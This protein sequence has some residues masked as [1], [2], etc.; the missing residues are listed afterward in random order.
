[1]RR[2]AMMFLA[3]TFLAA[4]ASTA[5]ATV[6]YPPGPP[7]RSCPDSVTLY[8]VQRDSTDGNTCQPAWGDTV[9]G[10]RGIVG[11]FRLRST[12]RIY[13]VNS[14]A[15]DYNGLQIYT[16]GHMESQGIAIG[17][18][19]SVCGISSVYQNE[20]EIIGTLGTSL[21]VRKIS[22]GNPLP[23]FRVGT[24]TTYKWTPASGAGS[25]YATCNPVEGMLVRVNGPLKVARRGPG[26]GLSG[27]GWWLCVNADGSA[28]GD[29]LLVEGAV[30]TAADIIAPPLGTTI[31]WVQGIMRRSSP[32]GTDAW[33]ISLRNASDISVQAP[34]NLSMAYPIAENKV[35]VV[36][37]KN[38]DVTTAQNTGNYALGSQLSGS[39][40]DNATVVG[41]AG[42][43]VDL[44]ISDI[45]P[46]FSVESV[47]T[48]GIG[49]ATCP[50][51]L[52]TQQSM[53]FILGVLTC[54]EVQAPLPDSLGGAHCADVS[55][56][57]GAGSALG[58]RVTVRGVFVA[59]YPV[60]R[61]FYFEDPEGGP[62]SGVVAYNVPFGP[63]VGHQY[64]LTCRVQEYYTM[65]EL[66]EPVAMIDEGV[67][68]VPNPELQPV[69]VLS[70]MSC[71]A[72][73]TMSTAEDYEGVLVRVENAKVVTTGSSFRV[74]A[75]APDYPD[76][77]SVSDYDGLYTFAATDT[78]MVVN[79]TGELFIN[80][81]GPRIGPRSDAD[82]TVLSGSPPSTPV[83][84][85]PTDGAT[86]VP[87]TTSLTVTASDPD[88]D[89]LTVQ[90]YGRKV[91]TPPTGPEFT[92]VLLPDTQFYTSEE[93]GGS[94]AIFKAQ[95]QWIVNNRVSRNI[96]A[97]AQL[98]DVTDNNVTAEW[99]RAD[100]AMK[101]IEDPVTTGLPSGIPYVMD[102]G[103]HDGDGTLFNQ[104][105]GV[106][107]FNGRSYY[108]GH[109][110]S[111]N[112]NSYILFSGA[113]HDFVMV[114]LRYAPSSAVLAWAHG[115]LAAYPSRLGIVVSHSILNVGNPATWTT[116][117]QPIY[118]ALKDVPNL[119]LMVCG[120]MHG[121]GRR[122]DVYG[123]HTLTSL[124]SDYQG[125][126]NGGNGY[127][128]YYEFAPAANQVRART[129]SPWLSQYEVD[130]DSSSQ[131]TLN[132]L[133]FGG[134]SV[135]DFALLGTV[136]GVP[137]GS[138]AVFQWS[139]LD[140][141][142]PYQWYVNVSDSHTGR[143]GPTW[144]FTTGSNTGVDGGVPGALALGPPSPNPARGALRFSFDLP[145][146][147]R[148]RLDVV[149]VQGRVVDVLAEGD[150]V[151][152]RYERVWNSSNARNRAAGLYFVRLE[153]PEGRLVRRAALLH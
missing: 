24:T 58:E 3:L 99:M 151:A 59:Q 31:D 127:L 145:R 144:S 119:I 22:S 100:T 129:Y 130:A 147:M 140:A 93:N 65:T 109:Y 55:R 123:G 56:F 33:S 137:S 70:D 13:L 45:L 108:G 34:P 115:V 153:T 136:A 46:R 68:G 6:K 117:G 62:R 84:V 54:K 142:A 107:R 11:G 12:G 86:G 134:S 52:S 38:V 43:V 73:Q 114:S 57:A 104:Y 26:A 112:S 87:R 44:T 21:T 78:G 132:N 35:R 141:V 152:G 71:D 9:L 149:D 94:N 77:L 148:V 88:A 53:S 122:T 19:I 10:L 101:V 50:V 80:E 89:A 32:S 106:S 60:A 105:F 49:S 18:S 98:G 97:V 76:T 7:Y 25:A 61:L 41:G 133:P 37:D 17:D 82:I 118:D 23:P 83:L 47:Q 8:Q 91:V 30:L 1:M 120:H 63:V 4:L 67:V 135:P 95:T 20:S 2:L 103:N 16:S 110:G 36:F 124:L 128:R 146:A 126:V 131:F 66:N 116:Q 15:A 96:V 64:L 85:G 42:A 69:G 72:T 125:Y 92:L 139:G 51:C 29:S 138:N 48:Q 40:V 143:N 81:N 39:T 75:P 28:P 79:V 121:E 102:I 113:G 90:F 5:M 111:D 14:N 74:A 27:T 150:F